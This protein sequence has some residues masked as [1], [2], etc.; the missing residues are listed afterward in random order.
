[1]DSESTDPTSE[2]NCQFYEKTKNIKIQSPKKKKFVRSPDSKFEFTQKNEN[3][4]KK[5]TDPDLSGEEEEKWRIFKRNNEE[6][7]RERDLYNN[8]N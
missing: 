3:P 8:D 5:I 2:K 1:M 4:E 7:K 6:R